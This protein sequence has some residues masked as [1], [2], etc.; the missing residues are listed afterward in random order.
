M[1][2]PLEEKEATTE[3]VTSGILSLLTMFPSGILLKQ[4]C[5]I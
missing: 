5:H 2:G 3:A 4:E 1:V